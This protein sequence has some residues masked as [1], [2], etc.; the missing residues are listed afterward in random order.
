LPQALQDRDYEYALRAL[1]RYGNVLAEYGADADPMLVR[2]PM[3]AASD[4]SGANATA[5]GRSYFW[6]AAL[7]IGGLAAVTVGVV[8]NVKRE[9]AAHEWNGPNCETPGSSR[10]QQCGAVND[11]VH[12]DERLSVG[13]YAGGGALL[14]AGVIALI[15]GANRES[16]APQTGLVG[17]AVSGPGVACSGS[18]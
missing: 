1:D 8:F 4:T 9:Q 7:G 3:R 2:K 5:Q 12:L 15:A 10:V 14:T 18:F 6:P 11:R 16:A 13:F 17:C